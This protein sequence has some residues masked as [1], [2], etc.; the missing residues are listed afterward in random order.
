MVPQPSGKW[1]GSKKNQAIFFQ[2]SLCDLTGHSVA[3]NFAQ[4]VA[5]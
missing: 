4:V 5:K 3:S 1:K 2:V